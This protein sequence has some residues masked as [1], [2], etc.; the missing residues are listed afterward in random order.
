PRLPKDKRQRPFDE[1]ELVALFSGDPSPR[2]QDFM[3]IAA[4]SGMRLHEIGDLTVQDCV[5]GLFNVREAKT[6]AGIR[7]V[8]IHSQ[9]VPLIERRSQGK[10]A[11][12][13]LFHE[14]PL[15]KERDLRKRAAPVSQEFGRYS[16]RLGI[17][18]FVVGSTRSLTDFHSFRRWFITQAEQ[19]D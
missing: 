19:G 18:T 7:K 12:T 6:E 4:L 5:D 10:A 15:R 13:F 1:N 16:R 2:L 8:P 14:L 3:L 11:P 9:L 17:A